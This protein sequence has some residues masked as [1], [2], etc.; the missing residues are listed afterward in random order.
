MLHL[1]KLNS[2]PFLKIADGT[3]T[4]ELRLNDE[5][6][7]LIKVGDY[8]EFT[9]VANSE[10]KIQVK[11]VNL[12]HF[13]SFEELY[14]VLPLNKCGYSTQELNTA[15]HTD[16]EKY[17]TKEEQAKYGVLGIEIVLAESKS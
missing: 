11:V 13:R 3:K 1:M 9:N 8:I 2:E 12:H 15:T 5:K 10:E 7:R 6:R 16:M 17:Y 14:A 4:I